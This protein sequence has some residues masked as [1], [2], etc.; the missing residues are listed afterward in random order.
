MRWGGRIIDDTELA[1]LTPPY[2]SAAVDEGRHLLIAPDDPIRFGNHSCD[3]NLWMHD[4]TSVSARRDIQAGEELTIDYALHTVT[5]SWS[6]TCTC[7]TSLCRGVVTGDDWRREDLRERY[8][9]HF[10]PFVNARIDAD[11]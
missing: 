4:A 6:M 1:V 2:S 5:P 7:G 8:R 11:A 9:G 10:S 3:P